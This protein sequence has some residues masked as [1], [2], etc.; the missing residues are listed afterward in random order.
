MHGSF[1]RAYYDTHYR[2]YRQQNPPR[3]LRHYRQAVERA[4]GRN[5]RARLL[6]VGCA[7]GAFVGAL[8]ERWE[9]YGVDP[10]E[11]AIEAARRIVPRAQF[12]NT[13]DGRMLVFDVP[14]DAITAWDVIEHIPNLD[15]VAQDVN[16]HLVRNGVFA[17][18][19]PVYDGLLGPV[20]NLLDGDPTHVH[21]KSRAFWLDWAGRHFVVEEWWG[22]FR[23]LLPGGHYVHWPTHALRGVAPAIAV[24]ARRKG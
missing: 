4:L 13:R 16:A 9:A 24:I 18:V 21:R 14:F 6:D 12:A 22:I 7:F 17:F 23:Y 20:V 3:K 2:N 1:E 10:S 11:Y 8:D 19:V 5:D 15:T